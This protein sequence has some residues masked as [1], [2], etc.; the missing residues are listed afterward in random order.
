MRMLPPKRMFR[1]EA[2]DAM[3]R[4]TTAAALVLIL[5][6]PSTAA[7]LSAPAQRAFE[8]YIATV[9]ARLT[10][11]HVSPDTCLATL[12]VPPAARANVER[13][14]K[15]GTVQVNPVNGGTWAIS[16]GLLHHWRGTAFIPGAKAADMLGLLRDYTG[17][18]RYYA[19]EVQSSHALEDRGD[20]ASVAMRLKKQEVVTVVLDAEYD[21]HT[22]LVAPAR[23]Y[24]ISRST[25]IWQVEE[26]GTAHEHR[27]P[28]GDDD[29]FLW[30]LNSYWSFVELPNGLL[31]ECEAVSLTRDVPNGLG[32]MI[33]PI[34]QDL[35]RES[36]EF[37]LNATR[38]ALEANTRKEAHR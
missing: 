20:S 5:A 7:R 36:L 31:I 37:T 32:W 23:G 3:T 35:P 27:R 29:G 21:V 14:L 22:G 19:P 9:E 28:E 6:V 17:L 18:A 12:N 4:R 24:S 25:H 33:G 2:N 16:G 38:N 26:A 15:S 11:Q 8:S 30:R 10:Q 13:Q 1:S 34:V